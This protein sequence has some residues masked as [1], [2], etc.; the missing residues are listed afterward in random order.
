MTSCFA[1][2]CKYFILT[3]H[4]EGCLDICDALGVRLAKAIMWKKL[5]AIYAYLVQIPLKI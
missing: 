4:M 5:K 3:Y 2:S 1:Q